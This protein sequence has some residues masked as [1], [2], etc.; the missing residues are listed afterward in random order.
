MATATRYIGK[1]LT[2]L[3]VRHVDMPVKR[4]RV[5]QLL[6]KARRAK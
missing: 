5:W 6:R 4:E 2:A 1:P 3:G